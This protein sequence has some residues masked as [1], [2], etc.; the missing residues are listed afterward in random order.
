MKTINKIVNFSG[1]FILCS[2]VY[3]ITIVICCIISLYDWE[4][5][6][7]EFAQF[8]FINDIKECHGG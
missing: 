3:T 4:R 8:H 5:A 2:I 7:R 6:K 1:A